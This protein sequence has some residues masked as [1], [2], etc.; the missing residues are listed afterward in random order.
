MAVLRSLLVCALWAVGATAVPA[1]RQAG[2]SLL[3]SNDDGW[4]E[5][6]I[7]ALYAEAKSAGYNVLLSA[8]AENQS[9]T[10]STSV[11]PTPL[12]EPGEFDSIPAGS[13]AEGHNATDDHIWYVN[14]HPVDA[15]QFGVQNLSST[16]LGGPPSLILTG[17]NVGNNLGIVTQFSGTV[18]AASEG[19]KLG[20]PSIAFSAA[21]GSERSYTELAPG[22]Y[23]YIYA[24]ASLRLAGALVQSGATPYLPA[25]TA[26]NVNFPAAGP[27]TDCASPEDF[28][29]VLSRVYSVLGLPVDV[30]TCGSSSLPSE[31]SVVG[32]DGCYASVSVF[33]ASSKTDA[34]KSDQQTVLNSLGALL[35]CLPND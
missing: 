19:A 12:D 22:D 24:Q 16:Y 9:G 4:A 13:P 2:V 34:S 29:F 1:R 31:S 3:L 6:N 27:G 23:S 35:T 8:P 10:G 14:A 15:V 26:L 32:T 33:K 21:T 7:R 20:I 30:Q 18:G 25:G 28:K 5:A 17:P 11:T